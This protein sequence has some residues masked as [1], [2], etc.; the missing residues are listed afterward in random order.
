[1][2]A[3][4]DGFGPMLRRLRVSA[5]FSQAALGR[6]G[7]P[8]RGRDRG[9]GGRAAQAPAGVHARLLA[10]ALELDQDARATLVRGAGA[11]AGSQ[12]RGAAA[13]AQRR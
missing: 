3:T 9:P 6:A 13:D 10:D 7:R 11:G 5:G 12:S 1:M 2:A 8:Q 4:P